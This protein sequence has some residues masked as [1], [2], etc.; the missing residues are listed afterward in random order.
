MNI[1]ETLLGVAGMESADLNLGQVEV[2]AEA[3][4]EAVLDKELAEVEAELATQ[5]KDIQ[6]NEVKLEIVS[7]KVEEL[8]AEVAGMESMLSGG[9]FNAVLFQDKFA[10][11]SRLNARLG[12]TPV[13]VQGS[14]AYADA[15]TAQIQSYSGMEA[16]KDTM[17]KAGSSVKK[18]FVDLYNSFIAWFTGIF[19][20]FKG[21]E[22]KAKALASKNTGEPKEKVNLSASASWLPDSGTL[23]PAG[24]MAKVVAAVDTAAKA[25]GAEGAL[26]AI[27]NAVKGLKELGTASQ[28]SSTENAETFKVSVGDGQFTIVYPKTV[29]GL[30]SVNVSGMSGG[31]AKKDETGYNKGKLG[32]ILANVTSQAKTLQFSKLDASALKSQRDATIAT[33]ERMAA[34][35]KADVKA[36]VAGIKAAVRAGLKLQ[37]GGQALA[38][39]L[40]QAQLSLVSA[41]F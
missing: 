6:E 31:E 41:H 32:T 11:A 12:A 22:A 2:T 34:E 38:A 3:V 27:Q 10:R 13:E 33:L 26:T 35:D 17:K 16:F 24:P 20:K 5:E 21:L 37:K 15:S 28:T 29:A 9:A 18:F 7:E 40:L 8:A 19:N 39:D 4:A 14:E 25:A 36:D 23:Q 1:T 30:S